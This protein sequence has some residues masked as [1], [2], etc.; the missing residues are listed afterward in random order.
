MNSQTR[1]KKKPEHYVNNKEFLQAMIL[2]KKSVNKAKREKQNKPP[3]P[4]YVG[5]VS[6]THLTLPTNREV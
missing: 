4:D 2:Y 1:I 6:Y 3:V 5:A